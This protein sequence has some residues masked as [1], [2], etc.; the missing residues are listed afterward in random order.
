[1]IHE[2]WRRLNNVWRREAGRNDG[3]VPAEGLWS[4]GDRIGEWGSSS[5][6]QAAVRKLNDSYQARYDAMHVSP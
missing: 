3:V 5:F 6:H 4:C 1:M 2:R